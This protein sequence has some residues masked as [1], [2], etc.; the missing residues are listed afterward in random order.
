MRRLP[1]QINYRLLIILSILIFA[2]SFFIFPSTIQGQ[3][4]IKI[5]K[6]VS[7]FMFFFGYV[8]WKRNLQQ[9]VGLF[10]FIISLNISLFTNKLI[11]L[12][13]D[14]YINSKLLGIN[15]LPTVSPA[16]AVNTMSGSFGCG[17]INS[18]LQSNFK[19]VSCKPF[20]C[21][22]ATATSAPR[23][24]LIHGLISYSMP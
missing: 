15:F 21:C 9:L 19:S 2:F 13:T 5:V 6:K 12:T 23:S 10:I 11:P 14:H 20:H 8:L 16:F 7:V 24:R 18:I 1:I 4:I 22:C 17:A 3:E